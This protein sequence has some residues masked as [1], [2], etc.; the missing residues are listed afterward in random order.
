M[1]KLST[2]MSILKNFKIFLG[3]T[4]VKKTKYPIVAILLFILALVLNIIQYVKGSLYLQKKI[5][6]NL[7]VNEKP[8][9]FQSI[10]LFLFDIIGINGF[11]QNTPVHIFLL[12]ISYILFGLIELNIGHTALLFF[13]CI[14]IFYLPFANNFSDIVCNN[15]PFPNSDYLRGSYCCGSFIS[16]SSVGF[17]LYLIQNNIKNLKL[18]LL[19]I[20]LI[21]C[22]GVGLILYDFYI[23]N[24]V[25]M[26]KDTKICHIFTWHLMN[27]ML[28]IFSGSVLGNFL[29]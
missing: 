18:R 27:Y 25:K 10:F 9:N 4:F 1:L 13:L 11:I 8:T 22:V 16:C 5:I 28:G 24:L 20:L 21:C 2:I 23:A 3:D 26:N 12:I 17:V 7:R 15:D 6:G 14:L 29:P 19:V